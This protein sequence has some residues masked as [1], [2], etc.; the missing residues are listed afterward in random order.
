MAI[1]Q[2]S[3]AEDI[4]SKQERAVLRGIYRA[5]QLTE[6]IIAIQKVDATL[7]AM[8]DRDP[9]KGTTSDSTRVAINQLKSFLARSVESALVSTKVP[10]SSAVE[11][12][13]STAKP[14]Q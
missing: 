4:L 8:S 7:V 13:S 3:L 1:V 2:A 11:K 14:A 10:A 6:A 9:I 5:S 12:I